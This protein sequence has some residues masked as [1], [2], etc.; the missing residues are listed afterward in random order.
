MF[1]LVEEVAGLGE[2]LRDSR[3]L[4]PVQYEI[5]RYQGVIESSGL[6]VPGLFRIEGRIEG[7]SDT[8]VAD[9]LNVPLVLRLSDGRALSITVVDQNGRVLSEGHGPSRCLCC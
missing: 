4:G 9:C 2:L 3:T 5:R 7:Q 6:P 1:K 8:A